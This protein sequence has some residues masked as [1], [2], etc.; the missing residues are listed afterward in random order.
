MAL[1]L[2]GVVRAADLV[3][4]EV[5]VPP[6]AADGPPLRAVTRDDLAA[7]VSPV[8]TDRELTDDDAVRHLDA[9][10]ALVARG[11]VLPLR[12]GTTAPDDEAVREE[13]LGAPADELRRRLSALDG[14]VEVRLDLVSRDER[15]L[16]PLLAGHQELHGLAARA[17]EPGTGMDEQL[18]LGEATAQLL[19]DLRA[20]R[21][22]EVA[23]ELSPLVERSRH[24]DAPR[25]EVERWAFLVGRGRLEELDSAIAGLRA[26]RGDELDLEYVG[27]LPTFSFLDWEQRPESTSAPSSRWGW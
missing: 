18:R 26:R 2:Y 25:P 17:R 27:P 15:D 19:G 3:A 8:D 20:R 10:T 13:V 4:G 22:E 6:G 7:V 5:P 14:V 16:P 9:L 1:H 21:G 23:E 11:P 12:F 24:L